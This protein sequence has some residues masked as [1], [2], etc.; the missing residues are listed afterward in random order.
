[1]ARQ[2]SRKNG[3]VLKSG[4]APPPPP[5]CICQRS[6]KP[7]C[8][9]P[10]NCTI[11]NVCYGC[12]VIRED[13]HNCETYVGQTSRMV[14]KRI[15]EHL[16]DARRYRPP[17]AKQTGSRLSQHIGNL[18]FHNIPHSLNWSI[19]A[20]KQPFNPVANFCMLCN[21]EKVLILYHP[22]LSTLNLRNELY[23]WCHH[24][25]RML[26]LNT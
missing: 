19:I 10:D 24:K 7:D 17:P 2:V 4:D 5:T 22:E 26:L 11:T 15:G 18:F 3:R 16:G 21:V 1:M 8:P 12:K 6:R 23:G 9:I 14:K 20:Q 25:E 13:N